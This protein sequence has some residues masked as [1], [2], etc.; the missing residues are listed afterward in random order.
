MSTRAQIIIRDK[1][2]SLWFYRH[3]D[4]YPDGTL[5]TLE[6]FMRLVKDGRIRN[7]VEQSAGWLVILGSVEYQT[8]SK[9][10]FPESGKDYT[11]R[12]DENIADALRD[13]CPTDWKVGAYEPCACRAEHG[14]IE[15]LYDLDIESLTIKVTP[16][17][18][19]EKPYFVEGWKPL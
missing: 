11:K 15:Y 10:S 17:N 19:R 3:S 2:Q 16:K 9:K 1:N 18:D 7:N 4:G 12:N 14:D 5:P 13:F 6:K 8:V